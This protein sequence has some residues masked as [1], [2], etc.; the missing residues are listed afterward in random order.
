MASDHDL[1]WKALADPTRRAILDLLR[2]APRQT[3]AIVERFPDLSRF[4]VMKHLE[5][6]RDAGLVRTRSAGR[7]R[8][9]SLNVAPLREILERWISKYEAYWANSLLRV[10][11]G[12]EFSAAAK[13]MR[14]S[15][16][17]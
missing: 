17:A 14:R 1:V 4:G 8:V 5:V 12:A 7:L 15:K 3:T 11:E 16:R 10:K 6:L 2:D 9:N 13:Q